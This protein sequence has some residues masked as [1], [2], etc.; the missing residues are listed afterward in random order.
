MTSIPE[1]NGTKNQ[2]IRSLKGSATMPSNDGKMVFSVEEFREG[3]NIGN[4]DSAKGDS[5]KG[6]KGEKSSGQVQRSFQGY[7][8][9]S[10]LA[11]HSD[12]GM[13]EAQKVAKLEKIRD[14]AKEYEGM[15]LNE[16]IKSMRQSPLVKTPGSDTYSEIAEKPFTAAITAAGGLGLADRI[17]EDVARQEGLLGTLSEHPEIM[18]PNWNPKISPSRMYKGVNMDNLETQSFRRAPDRTPNSLKEPLEANSAYNPSDETLA[19]LTELKGSLN[20][21]ELRRRYSPQNDSNDASL[22]GNY[23]EINYQDLNY[24]ELNYQEEDFQEEDYIAPIPLE[25]NRA[26]SLKNDKATP[27]KNN[28]ATSLEYNDV[29]LVE[30]DDVTLVEND[31]VTLIESNGASSLESDEVTSVD[32]PPLYQEGEKKPSKL[33]KSPNRLDLDQQNPSPFSVNSSPSS[34]NPGPSSVSTDLSRVNPGP[35]SVSPNPSNEGYVGVSYEAENHDSEDL[36]N[37]DDFVLESSIYDRYPHE[38]PS[39]SDIQVV[40]QGVS[41]GV[42][43][44]VY[45]GVSQDVYQDASQGVSQIVSQNDS[46]NDSQIKPFD[47]FYPKASTD[48]Q[49]DLQASA[50]DS[51]YASSIYDDIGNLSE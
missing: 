28:R 15:L 10:Y 24:Q 36:K 38:N 37:L 20:R 5:A 27:L 13:S 23:Q 46:Q 35:S 1:Y 44:D 32:L 9:R 21:E 45:Q 31:D 29:T 18:G 50:K 25:N 8:P 51:I 7:V 49:N 17:I 3:I 2:D 40:S 33:S 11:A 39:P 22:G 41:Q 12:R 26:T 19:R 4:K 14:S 43:Q 47:P 42:S 48:S 16:M 30:G 6:G 34:M